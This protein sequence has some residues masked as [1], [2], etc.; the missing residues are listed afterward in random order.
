MP[1]LGSLSIA[2]AG[3]LCAAFGTAVA[4][5]APYTN[6]GLAQMTSTALANEL[7]S[8]HDAQ[9]ARNELAAGPSAGE[10]PP[11]EVTES[12]GEVIGFP[13]GFTYAFDESISYPWGDTG[14]ARNELPGGFD[15]QLTA[16]IEPRTNVFFQYY[17]IQPQIEG[18]DYGSAPVYAPGANKPSGYL[19]LSLLDLGVSSKI[20]VFVAGFQRLFFVGGAA[21]N[22]GHPI[23]FAPTYA[24]VKG[25]IGGGALNTQLQYN[26]G[27][28]MRVVTRAFEQYAANLVIPISLTPKLYVLYFA[29][30]EALVAPEGFNQSNRVQFE[31]QGLI[32]Y[33]PNPQTTLFINP[34]K[35]MTY[36]PTDRYPVSTGNFVYGFVHRLRKP[37]KYNW[38]PLYLQG[39]VITSNPDNP[40]FNAYGVARLTVVPNVGIL[41][42]ISGNKFTTVQLSIGVGTPPQ[43][44]PYP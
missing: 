32:E 27:S 38:F 37:N 9:A 26:N 11:P 34:S 29:T 36:F 33:N 21:I 24:A 19:P 8:K 28:V 13:K 22:G 2:L 3:F 4:Q 44:V 1:R 39:E 5:T 35:A 14:E 15:A 7:R 42:T 18:I 41:P 16:R 40:D 20:D 31:Q 12:E 10:T 6:L 23:I 30:A 17:Q 25:D 43:I